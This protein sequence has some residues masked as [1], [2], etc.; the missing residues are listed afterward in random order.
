MHVHST[1]VMNTIHCSSTGVDY[2]VNIYQRRTNSSDNS[3]WIVRGV[4]TVTLGSPS[5]FDCV[6][7]TEGVTTT[8]QWSAMDDF[9]PVS[10]SSISNGQRL[11]LP[12]VQASQ[13]G[14][15]I[16]SDVEQGNDITLTITTGELNV[17]VLS[18]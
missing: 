11:G 10:Q 9:T 3:R 7:E 8:L 14:V 1:H 18:M 6:V 2:E 5:Y 16:C 4:A 12:S 15:Y 13:V 17:C